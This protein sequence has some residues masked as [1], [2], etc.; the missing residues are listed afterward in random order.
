MLFRRL[1]PRPLRDSLMGVVILWLF[2]SGSVAAQ[3]FLDL[4]IPEYEINNATMEEA[5]RKLNAWGIQACLE[6]V[7]R[8][9]EKE[10]EIRISVRLQDASVREVLNT[11]VS[12]D[13]RYTWERYRRSTSFEY[14][15]LIN[16]FPVGARKDP[17]NLMNIKARKVVIKF[18]TSPENLISKIEYFVPE[19]ARKLHH[20]AVAG[21]IP[22]GPIGGKVSLHIDFE[23]VDMTVREILNEIALRTAG[24]GWVYEC[25]KSPEPTHSWRVLSWS[26]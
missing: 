15:N 23:F 6:K 17:R 9:S 12:V 20:G 19:L 14:T 11:L 5:L 16:V 10:E 8:E 7:P 2:S 26:R 22:G 4:K 13:K 3:D 1:K 21:S 25:V 18:P 24:E